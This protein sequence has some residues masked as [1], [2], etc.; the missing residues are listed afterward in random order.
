MSKTIAV[1]AI[2]PEDVADVAGASRSI[3]LDAVS[4]ALQS[5]NRS[6]IRYC[7]LRAPGFS[8]QPALELDLL[9][10][11]SQIAHLAR[12]LRS[13]G[14]LSLPA[15]GH[16]PHHFFLTYS[17]ASHSWIK[18][19]VVGE[20]VYGRPARCLRV[21]LAEQCLRDRRLEGGHYLLA[22]R[23]EFLS[24]LLHCL[25]DKP[26]VDPRHLRRLH[27][28]WTDVREDAEVMR[29]VERWITGPGRSQALETD[30]F[31]QQQPALQALSRSTFRRLFRANPMNS[32]ARFYL[33]ALARRL[34]PLQVALRQ[35]GICVALLGPDGAGKTT[36]AD[37]LA[38][39]P[40]LQA[41]RIYMG[42]NDQ[43][44]TVSLPSTRWLRRRLSK[45]CRPSLLRG[46][47]RRALSVSR[48]LDYWWR[49]AVAAY[50]KRRG[51]L[52]ILDR[53]TYDE[54]VASPAKSPIKRLRRALVHLPIL[55]P[56]LVV[57]LDAPGSVLFARK[58]EHSPELLESRR[59][60]YLGLRER[61]PGVVVVDATQSPPELRRRMVSLIW[62]CIRN[63]GNQC[64]GSTSPGESLIEKQVAHQ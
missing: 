18:L 56:E 54:V 28:L 13:E 15:W 25:L 60:A 27:L 4:A 42:T 41:R 26:T 24:L 36:L 6:H 16:A 33:T 51:R 20:L 50:L 44:A 35:P 53:Y 62:N 55:R 11:R 39:E 2:T 30:I 48:V 46:L 43:A 7:L 22:P 52:V 10:D 31:G 29:F 12:L 9:V 5:L 47:T 49:L 14:Y 1:S 64:S 21:D 23:D 45:S 8:N 17:S 59:Q 37:A 34:R 58:G 3:V 19:D 57:V 61:V 32:A 40:Y 63:R 38:E